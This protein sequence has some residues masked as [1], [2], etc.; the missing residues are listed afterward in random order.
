MFQI[1]YMSCDWYTWSSRL[2]CYDLKFDF[3]VKGIISKQLFDC[4]RTEKLI[5]S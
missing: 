3:D 1:K 2:P 5:K 4:F